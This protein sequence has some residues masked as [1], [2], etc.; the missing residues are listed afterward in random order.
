MRFNY[1]TAPGSEPRASIKQKFLEVQEPFFKKVPA[2][3]QPEATLSYLAR[4][5]RNQKGPAR[6]EITNYKPQITNKFK[7]Q[8]FKIQNKKRLPRC[9]GQR[10]RI[11]LIFCLFF[12]CFLFIVPLLFVCDL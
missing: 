8:R 3:V 2:A 6:R 1:V 11:Y 5:S 4:S 12:V 9:Q 10:L 7:I